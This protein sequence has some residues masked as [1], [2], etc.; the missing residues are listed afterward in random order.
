MKP[1][2]SED[3]ALGTPAVVIHGGAGEFRTESSA[4]DLGRIEDDL[5]TALDAAWAVLGHG[6]PALEAVVAAVASLEA[7]GHFN[8]GRGA[9]ATANGGV[10]TD[11]AVMDGATGVVGA[12]CSATWPE[13][14]IRAALTVAAL[15]GPVDGPILLAGAGAD[16]FCEAAGL[17]P[18]DPAARTGEGTAPVSAAGTVG[19]VAVDRAGHVAAATSTGGRAGKLAGRVGDSPIVGAGTWAD[20][21][22]VAVSG[23]G[24]GEAF[25]VAGFAHRVEWNLAAG[26]SLEAALHQALD[27]VCA[28][29]GRGGGIAVA[30]DGRFAVAFNTSAMA[31]GWRG[32]GGSWVPSL[33]PTGGGNSAAS[34]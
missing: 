12:V 7:S 32:T 31:R 11:A 5:S 6:G 20:D 1:L 4:D 29:G 21:E 15:N 34:S 8:A 26:L 27:L 33:R 30:P 9:V 18:R 17:A 19:A 13:S 22:S 14:P 25:L 10:E 24:E 28:R 2:S 23:T 3:G 16:R